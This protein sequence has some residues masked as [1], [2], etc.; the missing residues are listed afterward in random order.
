MEKLTSELSKR[1]GA[2]VHSE[3]AAYKRRISKMSTEMKVEMAERNAYKSSCD[4][5]N[6]EMDLLNEEIKKWK[7]MYYELKRKLD[8]TK[9]SSTSSKPVVANSS[10]DNFPIYGLTEKTET[11]S[12]YISLPPLKKALKGE[13]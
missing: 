5:A 6:S 12:M 9:R 2:E 1:P 8:A 3:I 13:Q 7:E 4:K 10:S 11:P